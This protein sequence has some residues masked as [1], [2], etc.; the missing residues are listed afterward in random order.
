MVLCQLR[1]H[2][3]ACSRSFGLYLL[4]ATPMACSRVGLS[5]EQ[6]TSPFPL[7]ITG[8][9]DPPSDAASMLQAVLASSPLLSSLLISFLTSFSLVLSFCQRAFA[10]ARALSANTT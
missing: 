9:E 3:S 8:G 2:P 6:A 5:L 7:L 1:A 4:L 10:A